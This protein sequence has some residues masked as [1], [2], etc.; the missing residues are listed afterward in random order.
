MI[1]LGAE[2]DIDMRGATQD[3]RTFRLGDAARHRDD[4]LAAALVPLRLQA[5][6][7]AELREQLLR[8]LLPD[9]AGIED[10]HIGRLGPIGRGIA[11]RRQRLRHAG[12]VV[13]V[14]LAAVGLDE[15]G[16]RQARSVGLGVGSGGQEIGRGIAMEEFY[17]S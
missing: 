15:E 1:S 16:F 2:H 3:L 10:H 13:D 9:M 7:P 14:H 8:R 6:Q 17:H 4:Q 11:Q 5:A 12:G